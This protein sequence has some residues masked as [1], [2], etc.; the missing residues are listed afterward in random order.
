MYETKE[1]ILLKA[2]SLKQ[3]TFGQHDINNRL[4]I[5]NNKGSFGQII[6]EGFFGY[7]INSRPEADFLA[8]EIELKVTPFIQNKNHTFSSKERLVLNIIDFMSEDLN[9]F[10][11]S[12][13]WKKNKKLLIVFY[14]YEANKLAKDLMIHHVLYWEYNEKDLKIIKQDWQKIV[15]KIKNGEAHLI[16]EGDTLY[17]GACRKGN[18]DTKKVKQ[19]FSEILANKRAYSLKNGYMT[20]LLRTQVLNHRTPLESVIKNSDVL[21]EMT[22]E[23]YIIS[24]FRPYYGENVEAL[25]NRFQIETDSKAVNQILISKILDIEKDISNAEEFQKG[26]Y[27][28][29]TVRMNEKGNIKES[30]SFPKFSFVQLSQESWEESSIREMF[31]ETRFM[32]VVFKVS[33]SQEILEKIVFHSISEYDIDYNISAVFN[34]TKKIL[35]S[36]NIINSIDS[37]GY[38][39]YN[40]PRMKDNLVSHIRP[41]GRNRNDVDLLPVRDRLTNLDKIVK[42]CFWLNASYIKE[43]INGN[44]T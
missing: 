23:E 4:L 33:K 24:K 38:F 9:D 1:E 30:M 34:K 39:K 28:V 2:K 21:D 19:P 26:G 5:S 16:S 13:F 14:L 15:K 42:M 10:K 8:A 18:K 32:F 36:G 29:K 41:H 6:E 35:L 20:H 43:T 27:K 12:S 25:K 22:F 17:L 3:T 7:N 37:R 44:I 11:N 40:F 31:Y